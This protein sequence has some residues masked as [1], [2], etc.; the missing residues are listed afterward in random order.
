MGIKYPSKQTIINCW[1]NNRHGGGM[2]WTRGEKLEIFK[3][4]DLS[5]FLDKYEDIQRGGD[6]AMVL[7]FRIAT[8]GSINIDNCHPFLDAAQGLIFAHNGVLGIRAVGDWTDSETFF[9][10]YFLPAYKASDWQEG[11][12]VINKYIGGSRFVFMDDSGDIRLYGNFNEYRGCMWSNSTYLQWGR[13]N[14]QLT[15]RDWEDKK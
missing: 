11:E 8:H 3:T 9:R 4:M 5:K 14:I 7:H 2:S 1:N 15:T 12:K 6:C 13:S 10:R